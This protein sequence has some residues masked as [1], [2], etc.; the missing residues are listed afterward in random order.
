MK[1][2]RTNISN[3]TDVGNLK[4]LASFLISSLGKKSYEF[5]NFSEVPVPFFTIHE[6]FCSSNGK[7]NIS[8]DNTLDVE[9]SNL[10]TEYLALNKRVKPF[11]FALKQFI[12]KEGIDN[13]KYA[14]IEYN[15]KFAL[16]IVDFYREKWI[17]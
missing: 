15:F 3:N 11:L 16:K 8:V 12:K 17:P 10:I 4:R 7:F 1:A 2:E 5:F 6:R 9:R 14:H 13:G